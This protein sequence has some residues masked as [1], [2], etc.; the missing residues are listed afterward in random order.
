MTEKDMTVF[1]ETLKYLRYQGI[2]IAEFAKKI[3]IPKATLY[4]YISGQRPS[5]RSYRYIEYRL[6]KEYPEAIET[7]KAL[8]EE[9][10]M[11]V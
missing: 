3:G 5:E 9:T 11:R 2:T 8:V 6:K 1:R 4:N 7:G 10:E